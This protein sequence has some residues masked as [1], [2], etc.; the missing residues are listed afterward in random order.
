MVPFESTL[1]LNSFLEAILTLISPV[2]KLRGVI[3]YSTFGFDM[4]K[5]SDEI[6]FFGDTC[7]ALSKAEVLSILNQNRMLAVY[8]G[9]R[10]VCKGKCLK[11]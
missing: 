5:S 1:L 3:T 2:V 6:L 11:S 9:L 10:I 8:E 4:Q 7:G